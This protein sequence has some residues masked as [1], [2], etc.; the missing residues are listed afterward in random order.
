[1]QSQGEEFL[2]HLVVLE[3]HGDRQLKVD[4]K[5]DRFRCR[6]GKKSR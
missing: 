3:N 1:M 2:D 4:A 5:I 6:A